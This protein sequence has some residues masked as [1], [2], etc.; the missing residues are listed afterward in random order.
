MWRDHRQSKDAV[1]KSQR[2]LGY[3]L[4][5]Q[6]DILWRFFSRSGLNMINISLSYLQRK[7]TCSS[8]LLICRN[9]SNKRWTFEFLTWW[10][11]QEFRDFTCPSHS[12]RGC[13]KIWGNGFHPLVGNIWLDTP[14]K[15]NMVL[16]LKFCRVCWIQWLYTWRWFFLQFYGFGSDQTTS[17][18]SVGIQRFL[19]HLFSI[20]LEVD[21]KK[22]QKISCLLE[23]VFFGDVKEVV[24]GY[25]TDPKRAAVDV[26]FGEYYR[27]ECCFNGKSCPELLLHWYRVSESVLWSVWTIGWIGIL[28]MEF[29]L[30]M[31]MSISDF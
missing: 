23:V 26:F 17:T 9:P 8:N 22:L 11:P 5:C 29:I 7:R 15:T 3:F 30:V 27:D 19:G 2:T 16:S 1:Q 18:Q 31:L 20:V 14:R 24:L 25:F 28:Y 6:D 13:L 12:L 10:T 4:I 21:T